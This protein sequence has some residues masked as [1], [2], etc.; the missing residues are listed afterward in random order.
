[1]GVWGTVGELLD[2][3]VYSKVGNR[4]KVVALFDHAQK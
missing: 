2:A 1:M 4:F 3:N